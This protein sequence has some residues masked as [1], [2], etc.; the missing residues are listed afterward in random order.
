GCPDRACAAARGMG[1][2]ARRH[3][4]RGHPAQ[5]PIHPNY[6]RRDGGPCRRVYRGVHLG[7]RRRSL[8]GRKPSGKPRRVTGTAHGVGGGTPRRRRRRHSR[9]DRIA[10]S[11]R[12]LRLTRRHRTPRVCLGHPRPRSVQM[13][14][15]SA[16]GGAVGQSALGAQTGIANNLSSTGAGMVG[17]GQQQLGSAGKYFSTLASGN[18]AAT[19][20]ALA[21][22]VGN[23]NSVYGGTART[24]NRFTRGPDKT[25]QMAETERERA[26]QVSS[27]FR[28][29]PGQANQALATLGANNTSMGIGAQGTAAGIFGGQAGLSQNAQIASNQ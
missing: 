27:L 24:L 23:I 14:G 26:G 28:D 17:T 15:V 1:Y 13:G 8:G 4:P 16:G 29:A 12:P 7:P 5:S 10:G 9:P 2:Q 22:A 21:P 20:T 11:R 25:V 6:R 18:R 19:A 3:L